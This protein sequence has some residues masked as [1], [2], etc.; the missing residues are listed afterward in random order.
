MKKINN[1]Y[2][3][4]S[5]GSYSEAVLK[6]YFSKNSYIPCQ[7]FKEVVTKVGNKNYGLLPVENSLVGTVVDSYENLIESNL[8]VYGEFKK[9][10][11]HALIGLR[12]SKLEMVDKVISH[13][14][15]LQQCS[16]YLQTL[17]VELQPVFDTA[18]SVLSLLNNNSGTTAGIAG[19]HFENDE[20]F[21]ILKKNISNHV[22]NYTRFFLVGTEDPLLELNKDKRSAILIADDKPG[23]LLAALKI[24]EE[25]NVNLT[26][27]E[28]R[29]IIG[30][31]W[32]YKFYIDFQNSDEKVDFQLQNQLK[33]VTKKFK[34]IGKYG[35]VNL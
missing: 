23:S 30:S 17:N 21:N 32:E 11:S 9:K 16:N 5:E 4:G 20:R 2:Y 6:S 10:I 3:Q 18:G 13:P 14:Q 34:I 28:S 25:S 12:D 35:T 7:T 22:E 19:E 26:K 33:D 31:P 15:A 1:I 29:P 8:S 27:L 24:F